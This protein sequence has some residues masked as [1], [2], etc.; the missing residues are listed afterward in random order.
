MQNEEKRRTAEG[1]VIADGRAL[2]GWR[3]LRFHEPNLDWVLC[4][5]TL[6]VVFKICWAYKAGMGLFNRRSNGRINTIRQI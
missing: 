2:P 5:I 4:G 3:D 1:K 6:G